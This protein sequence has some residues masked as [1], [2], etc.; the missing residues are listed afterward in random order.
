MDY[1][2][3]EKKWQD[4]WDA[5]GSN[6]FDWSSDKPKYYVLEMFSYPSA[7]NLH[8]GHWYN[9][10]PSDTF[11]R[12]KKM[13]G[14]NVFHPMGFDSFGLPAENFA[15][16]T[17]VHPK[18]STEKNITTMLGQ[19]KSIGAMYDANSFL[20]TSRPEYYKWTQWLFLQLLKKG[21]AYQKNAPVNW[22]TSCNTVIANEQVLDGSCE[23]CKSEVIK[24]EMTQWFFKI[25][26]YAEELLACLDGLD[27]PEKTKSMQRNWIGKSI[28]A[29]ITFA[30]VP[31]R[32]A[33][34]KDVKD[35]IKVFT[36]RADTLFGVTYV[37]IAPE[38]PLASTLPTAAK[39]KAVTKYIQEATKQSD[40]ERLSTAKEKT[41]VFTGRYCINPAT[42]KRIPI[43]VADYCLATYGTGAV[44]AVPAHDDRDFAFATKYKLPIVTVIQSA[45]ANNDN[46]TS[47]AYTNDGILT[48]SKKFDGLTSAEARQK[49]VASLKAHGTLKT[50]YRLRDWSVSRQ[51][52]WGAP[53]PI[54][55]CQKCGAVPV[56]E[57]DL[58]IELPYNVEFAPDGKS[59][60]A[61]CASFTHTTCPKC[62]G[63]A[64]RD[65]DTLDTFVCSS[66][67]NL[68]YI[69]TKNT[70]EAFDPKLINKLMPVDKYVGG[71][72]HACMHLLYARFFNKALRDMGYVNCD[73]PFKS[74]VHQGII[75]GKDGQKMSKSKGN[76]VNPDIYV[77]EYG[78]DVFRMYLMFGFSFVEGGPWNDD[79]IKATVRFLERVE[80]IVRKV[81]EPT[82]IKQSGDI[83]EVEFVLHSTIK[84]IN[85]DLEVFSFNTAIARLF[86]LVNA[87][88]RYDTAG[89]DPTA[90]QD[91]CRTL[92]L[93]LAPFAPHFCEELWA[94]VI[95]TGKTC[96]IFDHS[97]PK[98][99]PSKLTKST[100]EVAVQFNSRVKCKITIP[101]GLDQAAA[102]KTAL[103][104][105]TV[106]AALN[107]I[108]P[109]KVIIVP[110]RLVNIIV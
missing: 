38:H 49:I 33:D 81:Y 88:Y 64:T 34:P 14:Y 73:E 51:R 18:D 100:V 58:P 20:V 87:I 60:L 45:D 99:D 27:W 39:K 53:I 110:D 42:K 35:Y 66:W 30:V 8:L 55:H 59:P 62:G 41:G 52:Y 40:I 15:I 77:D 2:A 105:P 31:P 19:L 78:S 61:K 23:R 28:G 56:P 6:N 76:V 69:D 46:T 75:L 32:S 1:K 85:E 50:N 74:L 13:Q 71:A 37:V 80:R 94:S 67:Y 5:N 106:I 16:K 21:L 26:H 104:D 9:Y 10:G 3:I 101:Q 93:L 57:K 83:S 47:G 97:Y 36:T 82:T 4:I 11:A 103:A 29:E 65:P 63:K 89:Y 95:N 72:E 12:Y 108:T 86:E 84:A 102:Q 98:H 7:S 96:S 109:K 17:G 92:I 44:M 70:K 79:G 22:C 91:T 48:N 90:L 54:I 107:G 43:Y 24:K 68:R 25:T